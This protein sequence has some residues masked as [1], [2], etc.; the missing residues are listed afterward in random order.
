MREQE[1]RRIRAENAYLAAA[2]ATQQ[3][4]NRELLEINANLRVERDATD[5]LLGEAMDALPGG[6]Q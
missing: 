6:P 5:I 3:L 4:R 2:V 1:Q